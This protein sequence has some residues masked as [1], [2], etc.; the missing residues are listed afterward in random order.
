M[1]RK[2]ASRIGR[3]DF[4]RT[5][6]D[7]GSKDDASPAQ[8]VYHY[9]LHSRAEGLG[10]FGFGNAR[11]V[12]IR[13]ELVLESP[14][15]SVCARWKTMQCGV[16]FGEAGRDKGRGLNKLGCHARPLCSLP[17]EDANYLGRTS[18][19]VEARVQ[20]TERT[21]T[22]K[23]VN[24]ALEGQYGVFGRRCSDGGSEGERGA[25]ASGRLRNGLAL[26][27]SICRESIVRSAV[28]DPAEKTRGVNN[29]R[30]GDMT[31]FAGRI[32]SSM[33]QCALVPPK[34][35]LPCQLNPSAQ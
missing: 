3:P 27:Y 14:R 35:K 1:S 22:R 4:A 24:E 8:Y 18:R 30:G 28:G 2:K 15:R 23:R 19:L 11:L 32:Y 7:D 6:A 17:R 34:P 10:E 16:E 31:R 13:Q 9:D 29:R 21:T 5:V 26:K 12:S 20:V 33:M 25:P